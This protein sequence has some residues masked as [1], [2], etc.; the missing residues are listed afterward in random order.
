MC[1]LSWNWGKNLAKFIF[2]T[3]CTLFLD[4]YFYGNQKL[5]WGKEGWGDKK[6]FNKEGPFCHHTKHINSPKC[7]GHI[8][9]LLVQYFSQCLGAIFSPIFNGC[10][11]TIHKIKNS[12]DL[13]DNKFQM[14]KKKAL[15]QK[16]VRCESFLVL[17]AGT[18]NN[19]NQHKTMKIGEK[20]GKLVWGRAGE[21]WGSAG[22][23]RGR[24]RKTVENNEIGGTQHGKVQGK[25]EEDLLKLL[26]NLGQLLYRSCTCLYH[27]NLSHL[28]L[29]DNQQARH[30]ANVFFAKYWFWLVQ[31]ASNI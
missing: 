19:E 6:V 28:Y 23:G 30:N 26:I 11:L 29:F 8:F 7:Q 14:T 17:S 15:T 5:S 16:D 27:G 21:A 18:T 4:F 31:M 3:F 10:T 2:H 12:L 22:E 24:R 1:C 20:W 25:H 13:C 9:W